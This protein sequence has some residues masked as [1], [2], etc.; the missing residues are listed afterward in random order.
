MIE[1]HASK[2]KAPNIHIIASISTPENKDDNGKNKQQPFEDV[3]PIKNGDFPAS[4]VN[5][6]EGTNSSFHFSEGS[7]KKIVLGSTRLVT[8]HEF[9]PVAKMH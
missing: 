2:A 9:V 3:S 6:L 4:H 8:G 5:L 1:F 7:L